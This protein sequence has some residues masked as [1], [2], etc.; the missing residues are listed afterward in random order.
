MENLF[1]FGLG[2]VIGTLIEF[3][4]KD[5][6]SAVGSFHISPVDEPYG[7]DDMYVVNIRL[8]RN[9]NLLTK[10]KIILYVNHSHK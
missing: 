1:F 7:E 9:K 6:N 10:R 4:F 5:R 3:I 2:I 8:P